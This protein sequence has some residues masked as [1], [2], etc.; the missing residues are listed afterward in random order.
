MRLASFPGY[1]IFVAFANLTQSRDGCQFVG[2]GKSRLDFLSVASAPC[3]SS[4][5]LFAPK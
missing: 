1:F 2:L 4:L 3:N 5:F